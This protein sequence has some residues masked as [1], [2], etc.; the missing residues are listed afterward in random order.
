MDKPNYP[1]NKRYNTYNDFLR[2]RH[3]EKVGKLSLNAGLTCPN[4]DG[5]IGTGGCVFCSEDGSGTFAGCS[6]LSIKEQM[7][8]QTTIQSK[9]WE[10]KKYIAY[11]QSYSNTYGEL[12][13]LR[14]LF[15]SA[16][17][18]PAVC[19]IA[20]ATRPDCL[21]TEVLD[22]LS[23]LN[24]KTHLWV[25]LGL[26]TIHERT[27]RWLNRGYKLD[28]FNDAVRRLGERNIEVVSHII[29][30]LPGETHEEMMETVKHVSKVGLKGVKIHL[31]HVIEGT[32]LNKIYEAEPFKI[33]E[34]EEYIDLVVEA[35]ELL[36]HQMIIHRLTGDG[37]KETLVAPRWP[38]NKRA[39]LN[40]ID[41]ALKERN[42]WQSKAFK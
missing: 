32:Q 11:F 14:K 28:V 26:Q 21:Q 15:Y 6:D 29:F 9:K 4:R 17:E 35:L 20:I 5:T 25:E 16:L 30:G 33:L 1:N 37:A 24:E 8:T 40:G 42:T 39:V 18:N 27:A 41:K 3:G 12:E 36:P 2:Q 38:L 10:V 7:A 13:N 19:G 31:L 34:Q 22:L 23:E